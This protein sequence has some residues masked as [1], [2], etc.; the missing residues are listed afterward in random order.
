MGRPR[1]GRCR[2]LFMRAEDEEVEKKANNRKE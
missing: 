1:S 2:E